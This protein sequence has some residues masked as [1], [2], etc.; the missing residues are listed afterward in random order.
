MATTLGC[1]TAELMGNGGLIQTLTT[2][3]FV[4]AQYGEYTVRDVM[5][6]LDKPGRDPRPEFKTAQ[7]AA[8]IE[9]I[10]DLHID[11]QLEGVITNVT[12]FGAFV[13]IGVH[14]DGLVHI[15]Q[16]SNHFVKD[17]HTL[18]KTGDIVHV[19][20][21]DV[22][23]ARRR[24]ALSMKSQTTPQKAATEGHRPTTPATPKANKPSNAQTSTHLNTGLAAGLKAA[25]FKVK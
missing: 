4:S 5:A 20:V 9:T 8:G 3:Q 14:Q 7:F 17:P 15:S 10:K 19:R 23:E 11:M 13:D 12:N 2:Q 24:I 25:G 22:D 1:K 16:L 6:E 21:T 18:V